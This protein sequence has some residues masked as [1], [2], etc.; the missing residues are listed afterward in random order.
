M[1]H[2][3]IIVSD[4]TLQKEVEKIEKRIEEA[5][6]IATADKMS[7]EELD[8]LM[9]K[10]FSVSSEDKAL[11]QKA[12][13]ELIKTNSGAQLLR[14]LEKNFNGQKV[15]LQTDQLKREGI[16]DD[17]GKIVDISRTHGFFPHGR[18]NLL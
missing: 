18:I 2:G 11:F 4:Q 8:K 10:L 16:K 12:F 17:S 14:S 1:N 15:T 6:K 13:S 5:L 3:V 7:Q 9:G